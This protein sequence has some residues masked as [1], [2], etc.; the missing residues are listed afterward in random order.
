M[1][2]KVSVLE[3]REA[4]LEVTENWQEIF[5]V[6]SPTELFYTNYSINQDK[7]SCGLIVACLT[8]ERN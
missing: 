6:F 7:I 3:Q 4:C 1:N 5:P 2:I 8:T